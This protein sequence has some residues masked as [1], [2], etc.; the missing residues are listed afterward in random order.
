MLNKL[1]LSS[2]LVLFLSQF[3]VAQNSEELS[4]RKHRKLAASLVEKGFYA[5]AA[6]NYESAF[7][8]NSDK[9]ELIYL[10]GENYYLAKE[11]GKAAEAYKFVKDEKDK[12]FDL[13]GL[14]YARSLKQS[15]DYET[16]IREFTYFQNAYNGDQKQMLKEVISNDIK[17]CE[18][19][20]KLKNDAPGKITLKHLG[21]QINTSENELAPFAFGDDLLYYTS[22]LSGK[23]AMIYR[24]QFQ[25]GVW[26]KYTTASGLPVNGDA[27]VA[28]GVFSPDG[29]RFYFT[30]SPIVV[31]G[32]KKTKNKNEQVAICEIY[33]IKKQDEGWSSPVRLRDY[34]NLKGFTTT[35]PH[36]VHT[37][38]KEI[39]YFSSNRDGGKGGMD[40]W[41][42]VRDLKSNDIDFT[43]PKNLGSTI[44]TKGDE[45]TPFY[46][47]EN[48]VLFFSSNG[49]VSIGGF[50]ILS[51]SGSLTNWE[52]PDNLGLPFNSEVDDYYYIQKKNKSGGFLVSNRAFGDQKRTTTNEDIFEYINPPII[53]EI[54]ARGSIFDKKNLTLVK[55]ANLS[56]Y[57]IVNNER[58]L[59]TSKVFSDGVYQFPLLLN[60]TYLLE[61]EKDG[62]ANS[63]I[64]IVTL[65]KVDPLGYG[66]S[67]YLAEPVVIKDTIDLATVIPDVISPSPDAA[68]QTIQANAKPPAN[69]P[70][71]KKQVQKKESP[72]K[73]IAASN[74][75]QYAA[76]DARKSDS[77]ALT[78][79]SLQSTSVV[80]N[81]NKELENVAGEIYKVQ[82]GAQAVYNPAHPHYQGLEDFGVIETDLASYPGIT[83][84]LI[85]N[86]ASRREAIMLLKRLKKKG[87]SDAFIVKYISGTRVSK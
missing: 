46:D 84:L 44:N 58:V 70:S 25:N 29:Q 32:E 35:H 13:V 66:E 56:L 34:I 21:E 37:E 86:L 30:Q 50:D 18:L 65:D 71:A 33:V 54:Y 42:C 82:I 67:I 62:Y 20:L 26:S 64:K 12:D 16:A 38:D 59:M 4:W 77:A 81:T 1:F 49:H 41:Y 80:A 85:G 69:K 31:A 15:G 73:E 14:K 87:F 43:F 9:K 10:A 2:L 75:P 11:F 28:N 53:P 83:R 57:E 40:I 8:K 47:A 48:G 52:K 55:G 76:N 23:K 74:I 60:K 5:D 24:S 27:H 36:L 78:K 3:A 72:G 61:A 6:M 19:A 39:L 51:S 68:D 79:D 45:I 7:K 63:D 17:G 22:T